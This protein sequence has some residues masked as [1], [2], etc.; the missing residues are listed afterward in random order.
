MRSVTIWTAIGIFSFTAFGI[1]MALGHRQEDAIEAIFVLQKDWQGFLGAAASLLG[2]FATIQAGR[3]AWIGIQ[4]QIENNKLIEDERLSRIARAKKSQILLDLNKISMYCRN[5]II[6]I[7]ESRKENTPP[8]IDES[9]VR[10]LATLVEFGDQNL[11]SDASQLIEAIQLADA[12]IANFD[13]EKETVSNATTMAALE[14]LSLMARCEKW[15]EVARHEKQ[16]I[17]GDIKISELKSALF[18]IERIF[19]GHLD[20]EDQEREDLEREMARR[21]AEQTPAASP[22]G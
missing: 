6:Y 7:Y 18:A 1:G 9:V 4:S 11:S 20:I 19:A 3:W 5:S 15:Y 21:F 2:A 8:T 13:F 14:C 16:K 10:N 17:D 22:P 12:W